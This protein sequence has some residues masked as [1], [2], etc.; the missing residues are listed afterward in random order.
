M[1]KLVLSLC[2]KTGNM[3]QPWLEAGYDCMVVDEQHPK[4]ITKNGKLTLVGADITK[5]LPPKTEY[6]IVF[7][8]PPC[9]NLAVSGA[10]W[11][12]DK[13]LTALI[14][15]LQTFEACIKIAEWSEAPYMIENPVS[16]VSSYYR[17]PDHTFQP[18][19]YAGYLQNPE[20]E[21]YHKRTCLWTGHGFQMP[22]TK[23]VPPTNKNYIQN[24]GETKNRAE[25]RSATPKGFAQAVYQTNSQQ[26]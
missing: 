19:E 26:K 14:E 1:S 25:K 5:W 10:A 22:P 11:F 16:T 12:H 8:F 17:K 13:G 4:G 23:P 7:A 24:M 3:I 9:T 15:G 20:D 18:T 21:A 2:D 6:E